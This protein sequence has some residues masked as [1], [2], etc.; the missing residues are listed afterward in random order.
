M[1]FH[2]EPLPGL[3]EHLQL[4]LFIQEC[5]V[6]GVMHNGNLLPSY[7]HAEADVERTLEMFA[8]SLETVALARRRG[9]V[10]GLLHL[11]PVQLMADVWT[12]RM[13][14]YEAARAAAGPG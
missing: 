3:A 12:A 7:A 1:T 6:R 4:S 5:L 9:A 10:D 2:F 13:R 8:E 14:S 11:R